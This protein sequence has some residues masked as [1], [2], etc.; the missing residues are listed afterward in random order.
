M[1]GQAV[2]I[3]DRYSACFVNKVDLKQPEILWCIFLH[4]CACT[5][6]ENPYLPLCG[7]CLYVLLTV[8]DCDLRSRCELR[9]SCRWVLKTGVPEGPPPSNLIRLQRNV[10][11]WM[12]AVTPL[13]RPNAGKCG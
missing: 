3:K 7:P 1:S 6:Y 13:Q 12:S 2:E 9:L 5:S 11:T 8:N 4:R 10:L